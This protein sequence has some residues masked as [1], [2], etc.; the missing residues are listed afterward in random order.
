MEL[1]E[2]GRVSVVMM[3]NHLEKPKVAFVSVFCDI[4]GCS[5]AQVVSTK[6]LETGTCRAGFPSSRWCST[7]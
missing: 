7:L 5:L 6:I 2:E 4:V 1:S 3:W